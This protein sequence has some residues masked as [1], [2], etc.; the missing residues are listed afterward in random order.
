MNV[1]ILAAGK[2]ER[3]RPL[4]E[5]LPKPLLEVGGKS[6]IEHTI[7]R[8]H[9]LGIERVVI[10]A[11][12]LADRL[13]GFVGDGSQWGVEVVWS[14]EDRL[15]NTGGGV[16]NALPKLGGGPTLLINGDILWNFDLLPLMERFDEKKMDGLLGL[17]ENPD[18]KKSDFFCDPQGGM[19]ERAHEKEGGYT[20]SGIMIFSTELLASY[21]QEPFSLNLFFDKA[22]ATNRLYGLP[23]SGR[24]ADMGTPE[25]LAQVQK[26]WHNGLDDL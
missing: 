18:Y 11:W 6:I 4:T 13:M 1:M 20:Y 19:L 23:L 5:Y 22:M 10:N 17:I 2:G 25:R 7:Q 16:R 9:G 8:L 24:W 21:P 26:E 15:L 3:L 12:Y 14:P